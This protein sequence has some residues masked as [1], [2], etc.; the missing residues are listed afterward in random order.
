[1]QRLERMLTASQASDVERALVERFDLEPFSDF[2]ASTQERAVERMIKQRTREILDELDQSG[3]ELDIKSTQF[4]LGGHVKKI[5]LDAPDLQEV[6]DSIPEKYF[7]MPEIKTE[8]PPILEFPVEKHIDYNLIEAEIRALPASPVE[9][10]EKHI[11]TN[12]IQAT[13]EIPVE[14][15]LDAILNQQDLDSV[16]EALA[17]SASERDRGNEAALKE[18]L[19]AE[20]DELLAP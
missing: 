9:I 14:E 11:D 1:M 4:D 6:M 20:L 8:V 19:V 2:S 17:P 15:L 5:V 13:P 16:P 7:S 10:L 18:E 12:L 3:N